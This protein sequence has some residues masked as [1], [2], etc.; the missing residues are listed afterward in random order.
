M[1]RYQ[2]RFLREAL[3]Q[4]GWNVSET[5]RRIGLARSHLNDLIKAHGLSRARK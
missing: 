2:G 1:R 4:G 5:A 3:E